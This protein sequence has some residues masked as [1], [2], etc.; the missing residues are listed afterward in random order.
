MTQKSPV[1]R[2]Q[3]SKPR[4]RSGLVSSKK[5]YFSTFNSRV[6]VA[7][8]KVLGWC[9]EVNWYIIIIIIIIIT[10]DDHVLSYL[11][12][13][14]KFSYNNKKIYKSADIL[15]VFLIL[16]WWAAT[17]ILLLFISFKFFYFIIFKVF[18]MYNQI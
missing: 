5:F 2:M 15:L 14:W 18:F 13:H 6:A 9:S 11:S 17:K 3:K 8:N 1:P 16:S 7:L 10:S 4:T 12:W